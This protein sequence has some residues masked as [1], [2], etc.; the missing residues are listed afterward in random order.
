MILIQ[1][2]RLET[3]ITFNSK[4]QAGL[5]LWID[6]N[7]KNFASHQNVFHSTLFGIWWI[8]L[9]VGNQLHVTEKHKKKWKSNKKKMTKMLRQW[10]WGQTVRDFSLAYFSEKGREV[11]CLLLSMLPSKALSSCVCRLL[12]NLKN[13]TN[14]ES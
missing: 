10:R 4:V 12:G 8:S 6:T 2:Y 9:L 5:Y 11:S 1:L 14:S 7:P 13:F 3:H